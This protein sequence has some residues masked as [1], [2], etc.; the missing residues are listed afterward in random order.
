MPELMRYNAPLLA[1][2]LGELFP[3]KEELTRCQQFSVTVEDKPVSPPV[4]SE[5]LIERLKKRYARLAVFGLQRSE[6][7]IRSSF[8][9]HLLMNVDLFVFKVDIF[10]AQGKTLA[11]ACA[12]VQEHICI[13]IAALYGFSDLVLRQALPCTCFQ[14]SRKGSLPCGITLYDTILHS[15]VKGLAEHYIPQIYGLPGKVAGYQELN[16]L[17]YLQR[18]NFRDPALSEKGFAVLDGLAV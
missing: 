12:C 2:A 7:R 4:R 16:E 1:Y 11:A 14:T 17:I 13:D 10:P 9:H 18:Q 3:H 6:I 15:P 8:P 5:K